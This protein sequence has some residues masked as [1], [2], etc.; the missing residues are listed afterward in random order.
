LWDNNLWNEW[1]KNIA[2]NLKLKNWVSLDLSGNK[3]DDEWLNEILKMDFKDWVYIDLSNNDI[4]DEWIKKLYYK[5]KYEPDI[6]VRFDL[7][8]NRISNKTQYEIY[9]DLFAKRTRNPRWIHVI[10]DNIY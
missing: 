10:V 3:I 8:R 9:W 1:A 4:T 5:F 6:N 2:K 7:S